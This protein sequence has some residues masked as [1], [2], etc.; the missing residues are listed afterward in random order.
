MIRNPVS[1]VML[2]SF[3]T[4]GSF[5]TFNALRYGAVDFISKP[6]ATDVNELYQKLEEIRHK[7]KFAANVEVE[8][9]KY[10]RNYG[11]RSTENHFDDATRC[12]K[13]VVMGAGEGAYGALLKIIPQLRAEQ[14]AAYIVT[15]Y[16]AP[17]HVDAFVKYLNECSTVDVQRAS[18]DQIVKPGVCY[19]CAGEEYTTLHQL[20]DDSYSLQINP[21]PFKS[22]RGTVDMLLF[23]TADIMA[24]DCVGII[25]SGAGSDGTEGLEE[26]AR[27]GGHAIVQDPKTC[28]SAE[29]PTNAK[30]IVASA[31]VVA[32]VNIVSRVQSILD[33]QFDSDSL[34][35]SSGF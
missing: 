1:V 30:R 34:P 11:N 28:L 12:E 35:L 9:I 17:E 22:R 2:S 29:M 16:A 21:A 19:L 25:L 4:V 33:Q 23:S 6:A 7:V 18:H 15:M 24:E 31:Q 20:E 5:V 26:V 8:S 32:D 27:M 13:I 14:A 10:I 3:T